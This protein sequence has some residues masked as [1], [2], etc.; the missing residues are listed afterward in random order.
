MCST[1][2]AIN[3]PFAFESTARP[4]TSVLPLFILDGYRRMVQRASLDKNRRT[5]M[6]CKVSTLLPTALFTALCV[7]VFGST[8][9]AA[10]A[11]GPTT[12]DLSSVPMV[13]R[14]ACQRRAAREF[15]VKMRNVR[16]TGLRLDRSAFRTLYL[17]NLRSDQTATCEVN[18]RN[19]SVVS[20][21]MN[22]PGP[23]GDQAAQETVLEFET[24][25]YRVRVYRLASGTTRMDVFNKGTS[26]AALSG[27]PA[28]NYAAQGFTA[29][30]ACTNNRNPC[31]GTEYIAKLEDSGRKSL[32]VKLKPNS[33]GVTEAAV[34]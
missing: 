21:E 9:C 12:T 27:N 6:K 19:H 7:T 32:T 31:T 10:A 24:Q 11:Q 28:A 30:N 13:S 16:I 15:G 2:R 4:S 20:F 18:P 22:A 3:K 23:G 26:R 17:K 29:Y 14:I 8:L 33:A 34:R 5:N 1:G 25:T